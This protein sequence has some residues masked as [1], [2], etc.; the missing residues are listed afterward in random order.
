MKLGCLCNYHKGRAATRHY[1]IQPPSPVWENSQLILREPFIWP[2]FEALVHAAP[3]VREISADLATFGTRARLQFF[4]DTNFTYT[5]SINPS[6]DCHGRGRGQ[7]D[8]DTLDTDHVLIILNCR[9]PGSDRHVIILQYR[10]PNTNIISFIYTLLLSS[11]WKEW[12]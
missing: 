2:S 5:K 8:P 1:A 12:F 4:P 9:H 3:K 11:G 6:C 10:Y 7:G